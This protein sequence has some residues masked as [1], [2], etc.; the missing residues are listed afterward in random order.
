MPVLPCSQP[1]LRR[2]APRRRPT[3]RAFVCA[4]L[5]GASAGVGATDRRSDAAIDIRTDVTTDCPPAP[6]DSA[7]ALQIDSTVGAPDRGFLWRVRRDGRDA[8]LYGTIHVGKAAWRTPGPRVAQALAASDTLAL[9]LDPLDPDVLR[10]LQLGVAARPERTLPPAL[11][12]RIERLARAECLPPRALTDV[13][14]E[15]QVAALLG[16]QA[17]RE[18]FHATFGVDTLLARWGHAEHLKVVSLETPELQL[19]A[20][21]NLPPPPEPPDRAAPPAPPAA[22]G[23]EWHHAIAH[24]LDAIETGRARPLLARIAQIWE[25][26]DLAG[27]QGYTDWCECMDSAPQRSAM[28]RA[29]D[30]RNPALADAIVALH[31]RGQRVF[32]AVGS[33]HLV[34]P[35]GLPALLAQRG[36]QVE[37]LN[38]DVP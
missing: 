8:Y 30:A 34:G 6:I 14:P 17:R 27:L 9:E 24:A 31:A 11:A 21:Q 3:W 36:F 13:I 23:P 5:L 16:L 19:Q 7:P 22:A 2:G 29:L 33:L 28:A 20:M 25:S 38:A 10:R 32:A 35:L 37:R 4:V 12:Q 26:G 18:G 15:I 1:A